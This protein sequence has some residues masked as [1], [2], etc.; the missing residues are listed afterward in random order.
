MIFWDFPH[1][2][3]GWL[4]LLLNVSSFP[5]LSTFPHI[6]PGWAQHHAS[7]LSTSTDTIVYSYFAPL[8][9]AGMPSSSTR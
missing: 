1:H 7:S 9:G 2:L 5:V 6:L 4:K 8:H 3:P